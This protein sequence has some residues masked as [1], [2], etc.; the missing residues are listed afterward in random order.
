MMN[1]LDTAV[2]VFQTVLH[3]VQLLLHF[4]FRMCTLSH[5]PISE[6]HNH[7]Q[8]GHDDQKPVW[9]GQVD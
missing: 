9:T 3:V 6:E 2:L 8:E 5:V 1:F 7:H 4:R